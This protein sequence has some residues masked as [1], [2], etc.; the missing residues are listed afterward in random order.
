MVFGLVLQILAVKD[1]IKK[2]IE[3]ELDG[4]YAL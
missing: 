2:Y 1:H 4:L 3:R